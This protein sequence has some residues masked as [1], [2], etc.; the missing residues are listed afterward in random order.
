M[1][2]ELPDDIITAYRSWQEV[3]ARYPPDA[4]SY[5]RTHSDNVKLGKRWAK[6][7]KVIVAHGLD[8]LTALPKLPV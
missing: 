6:L 5:D 8:L 4:G 7:E 2:N 3:M 1:K